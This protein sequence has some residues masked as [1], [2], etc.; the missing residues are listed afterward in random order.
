MTGTELPLAIVESCSMYHNGN[1]LSNFD[2]WFLKNEEKYSAF[3]VD[4]DKFKSFWFEKGLNK[5]DILFVLGA[6]YFTKPA[7]YFF[8]IKRIGSLQFSG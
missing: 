3:G 5:G 2:S 1:L 8:L 4:K 7:V 6:V